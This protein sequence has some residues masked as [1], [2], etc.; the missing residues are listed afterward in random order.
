M[1]VYV[2]TKEDSGLRLDFVM[3]NKINRLSRSFINQLAGDGKI[4]VNNKLSKPSH[5]L[6]IGDKI[7]VDFDLATLD[8]VAKLKLPIIYEDEDC[9]VINK[10]EGILTHSKGS[11]NPE[12]TVASWLKERLLNHNSSI[13]RYDP[14]SS[15]SPENSGHENGRE[16]IVHRLDRGTSG[17][18]ICAKNQEAQKFL[19][20]QFSQ[21]LVKKTYIAAV[22]GTLNPPE[23]IIDIPIERN[24]KKPQTFRTGPNGKSAVTKYK[25]LKVGSNYSLVEL[26]PQTG[27]THQLRVH[28]K[29][30]G[31]PVVGDS[32]YGGEQADRLYLHALKLEITLPGG[33]QRKFESPLPPEFNKMVK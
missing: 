5:K 9:V 15:E 20:K 13:T 17:V 14:E 31:H 19:Q 26:C 2:A 6:K 32:F 23:A 28:L 8:K 16:G 11:F 24:P 4:T 18:I 30:L 27:R 3:A 21:R 29:Q 22:R 33:Q 1:P 25:T 10:P 7:N 12:G